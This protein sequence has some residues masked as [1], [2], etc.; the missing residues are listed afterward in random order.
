V[1]PRR[2][3]GEVPLHAPGLDLVEHL[4]VAGLIDPGLDRHSLHQEHD[5][6]RRLT[7]NAELVDGCGHRIAK[8]EGPVLLRQ[9]PELGSDGGERRA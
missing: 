6:L 8:K 4:G 7:A 9:K 3:S 2:L 5:A 1:L